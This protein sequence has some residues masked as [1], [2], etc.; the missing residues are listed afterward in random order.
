MKYA[1]KQNSGLRCNARSGEAIPLRHSQA[2][3]EGVRAERDNAVRA[4]RYF[5]TW[6]ASS[7]L[8]DSN[9]DTASALMVTP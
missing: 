6:V 8:M 1:A 5:A 4:N 3:G 2:Y 7:K 9:F